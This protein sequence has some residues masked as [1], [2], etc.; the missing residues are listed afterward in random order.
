[1]YRFLQSLLTLVLCIVSSSL[2]ADWPTYLQNNAR[3]G[4]TVEALPRGLAP[5]WVYSTPA[6]PELAFSGPR[7]DPIEGKVMRHRVAFDRALQPVAADGRVFFGSS[8]DHNLY[9]RDAASGKML[10]SF[11]TEGPIRLAPTVWQGKV[12]FGSDDGFVYC[13]QAKDGSVVWKDQASLRDERLLARG[14]L[15]SRWPVRTGVV[16]Y[17]GIAYFGAGV[18]PHE[19][20]YLVARDATSGAL[21]WRNDHISQEDA[22]RNP[23]SP[24][25]YLLANEKYL[26]VPSGRSLPAAFLRETGEELHQRSHSWRSSA[27]GVVGSSRALLADGQI[28]SAGA[29][30]FLALDQESGSV[31]FAWIDGRQLV[32]SG[33]RGFVATE[34]KIVAIDRVAHAKA[35]IERQK[36]NLDLSTLKRKRNELDADDYTAQ[37]QALETKIK[38]LGQV[39]SLWE[40]ESPLGS[41]LIV[42]RNLLVA[43]GQGKVASFDVA[44]G[45]QVW[46]AEV[47]GDAVGLVASE[48][49]LLVST[50]TGKIY[51]F[52]EKELVKNN[53]AQWPREYVENPYPRD[54]W[55]A[56]YEQAAKSILARSGQQKG[57]CVIL[58]SEHGRL[59]YELARH[60]TLRIYGVEPDPA[61]ALAARKALDRA[62]LHGSRITILQADPDDMPVSNFFANLVVSDSLIRDGSIPVENDGWTRIVKPCGGVVCFAVP[63]EAAKEHGLTQEKLVSRLAG[64]G[65]EATQTRL[66]QFPGEEGLLA[67]LTRGKLP[68][69]GDWSHQ[70]GNVANTMTSDDHRLK[71]GLGILWYGDPGPSQMVNRHEGASA[72]LSTNGRMFIQGID[73]VMCYDAYNGMFLWEAKNPGAL[74][75]GVFNNEETSNLAASDDAVF[76][77]VNDTCTMYDAATGK[78]LNEFKAPQSDDSVP[79][80]WGYIAQSDGLLIGTSTVRKELAASLRRRG[81][82]VDNETDAL[83]AYDV[84]TGKQRWLYRGKNVLHVTI[85]IDRG[86]VFFIDSSISSAQREALL[87]QDKEALKNL[88]PEEA[89]K[90]EEELKKLDVRLAVAID[91]G[92]GEQLWSRA[93]DVTDCSRVGIG[94][95]QL[96]LMAHDGHVLVCGANANG[97][98]WRQFLSGQFSTRR[99]VVLDAEKGD[100]LWKKDAN[101]RHRPIIVGEEVLAEP[102]GFNLHT[103]EP[104]MREHPLTGEQTVWQFSRPGHHCGPITA[105]P[106]MLFFRSGFTGYYDLY[107]D[108]GTSHFAGHRMGCWVN[109]IPGNGLLMIPEAS[110]GCVCQFSITSTVVMEP[111]V[112]R[113]SWRIY[114]AT[115]L[116]TPVKSMAL[117]IGA[118]GDRRDDSGTLWLGW[119]RPKTVG[120]LE[121]EFDIQPKYLGSPLTASFNSDT[122]RVENE[123][124]D[125]IASSGIRGLGS[126]SLPLLG[127]DDAPGSYEVVLHLVVLDETQKQTEPLDIKIQGETR[128]TGV[129]VLKQAGGPR[130]AVT[131]TY[132]VEVKDNLRVELV[133]SAENPNLEQLPVV[134]AV[135]VQRKP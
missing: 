5:A 36:L 106:N 37:V 18:F 133:P 107:S 22:G 88:G 99:L 32:V 82:T 27:G 35:T 112:D 95:G 126:F 109:A 131:L 100:L 125:W 57:F 132:Q 86:R 77:A 63:T 117:N 56:I 83:F 2:A 69:A 25:G 115:G 51:G 40:T 87:R 124:P 6:A 10:W 55:T 20:I 12:Y 89:K 98:Y 26:F 13:L 47:E 62:G 8:V 78:I 33:D 29:Q 80:I 92:T 74:R 102:W 64:I 7:Q 54:K 94:G 16:I 90:K 17:D 127:S 4:G 104:K 81:H 134:T 135:E 11:Y 3:D 75:T 130:K 85:A 21:V 72:P 118:P 15:I 38:Q 84:E 101:Y 31:G 28:Y 44:T 96:T 110:A 48:G 52:L 128:A 41:S 103:G 24:Q 108:S 116:K 58:G 93:V 59:A 19:T 121:Y 46:Q 70:Y 79:R 76:V 45:E 34:K 105:A 61:K 1:M 67:T 42:T 91:V 66:Q 49:R 97:H 123:E 65:M 68:G 111:R 129:D 50:D 43:G 30:H 39:G 60:S 53:P 71:G 23:L 73:S 122:V 14:R 113:N 114:S 120:R 9:C 119:P